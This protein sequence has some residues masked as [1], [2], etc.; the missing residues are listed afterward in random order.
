M[1]CIFYRL[2]INVSQMLP[3]DIKET[4]DIAKLH[5]LVEQ[6][7]RRFKTFNCQWIAN[8]FC[9]QFRWHHSNMCSINFESPI[10]K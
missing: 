4:N 1:H 7:R 6:V 3:K 5:I 10:Y 2:D 8:I 9:E